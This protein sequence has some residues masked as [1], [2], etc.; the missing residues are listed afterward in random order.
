M[1]YNQGTIT[2]EYHDPT[3]YIENNRAVFELDG[4][5]EGY[6]PNMRLLNLGCSGNA[7]LLKTLD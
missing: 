6:L 7:V 4:S 1:S 2:T 5:K 3:I